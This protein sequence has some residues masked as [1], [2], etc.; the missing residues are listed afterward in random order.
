MHHFS[1]SIAKTLRASVTQNI[2]T[3]IDKLSPTAQLRAF[4]LMQ[5]P[6]LFLVNPRVVHIDDDE[7]QVLIPLNRMTK[8]HLGSMYFGTLAIGADASLALFAMHVAK[9]DKDATISVVFK[10]FK[11]DFLKRPEKDVIFRCEKGQQIR[12]MIKKAHET[13]ERVTEGVDV[14][15]YSADDLTD[16]VAKFTL[17]LSIRVKRN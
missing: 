8:N 3:V 6:L 1:M 17:G 7:C 15:G 5:I 4:G 11:A 14:E 10:D 13:G 9:K 2:N 12:A 16:M